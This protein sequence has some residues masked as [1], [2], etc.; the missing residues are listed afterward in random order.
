[1]VTLHNLDFS[2]LQDIDTNYA[3]Q[4]TVPQ[5]KSDMFLVYT[6]YYNFDL[7]SII[8]YTGRNYTAAH[9][10]IESSVSTLTSAECDQQ[11]MDEVQSIMT[12][13]C[14]TY[15]NAESSQ[16]NFELFA[17]YGN[18]TTITKNINKVLKDIN[19][20]TRHCYG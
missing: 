19:N 10:D 6:I 18:H 15:L 14:S 3:S 12:I 5:F 16:A 9:Q 13:C 4:Q 7:P 8:I 1:M 2:S 11:L 17:N 20:E